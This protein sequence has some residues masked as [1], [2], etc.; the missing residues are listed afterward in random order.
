MG[1]A[2]GDELRG[3][4][5]GRLPAG[6]FAGTPD[7]VVDREEITIVGPIAGPRRAARRPLWPPRRTAGPGGSARKP[8]T[9]ASRSRARPR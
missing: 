9:T 5:T 1:A 4:F 3:W 2:P 6:W 7:V 8:G